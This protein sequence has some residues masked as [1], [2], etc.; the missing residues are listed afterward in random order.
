MATTLKRSYSSQ[1]DVPTNIFIEKDGAW[2]WNPDVEVEGMVQASKLE[3]FRDSN[4]QLK[5]H[6]EKFGVTIN[7]DQT[8]RVTGFGGTDPDK[9]TELQSRAQELEDGRLTKK[10]DV[11]AAVERRVGEERQKWEKEKKGMET[12]YNDLHAKHRKAVIEQRALEL[13]IPFGLK[14]DEG[15]KNALVLAINSSWNLGD[16]GEP[17]AFEADGKTVKYDS[18]G[19]PKRGVEALKR[20]IESM[21]KDSY[22]FL[23]EDNQGGGADGS[24][25]SGGGR[26]DLEVNPFDPKT[27]NRTKQTELV[28][29]DFAKAQRMARKH[30]IDLQPSSVTRAA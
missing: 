15:A 14:K 13:A 24:T 7:T 18:H 26:D 29:S 23:F 17:V 4:V 21:A 30:G 20:E 16:D 19:N 8:G 28:K 12:K 25:R 5:R 1:A 2:V 11:E 3:P 27:Y 6:L 10:S 22:K 9:V